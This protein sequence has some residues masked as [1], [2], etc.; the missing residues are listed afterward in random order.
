M[1]EKQHECPHAVIGPR[2]QDLLALDAVLGSKQP[3]QKEK[4]V[5]R[6][7]T[8]FNSISKQM[9]D[10]TLMRNLSR[11]TIIVWCPEEDSNHS[12]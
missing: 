5:R 6:S 8:I 4:L 2:P 9:V 11:I 10:H 7:L 1:R 3:D 12:V